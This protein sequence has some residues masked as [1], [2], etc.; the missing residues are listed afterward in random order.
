[1]DRVDPTDVIG[2]ANIS[3]PLTVQNDLPSAVRIEKL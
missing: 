3:V 1:M 2:I